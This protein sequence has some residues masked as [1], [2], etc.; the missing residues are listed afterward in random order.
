M[1]AVWRAANYC[2][3]IDVSPEDATHVALRFPCMESYLILPVIQRGSRDNH[4]RSPVWTWNGSTEAPTLK[5]SIRTRHE[6]GLSHV[7]L[8][9][10]RV[11]Y[12]NDSTHELAGQ[13]VDL[14]EVDW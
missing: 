6:K 3:Y 5:P 9:D 10:G 11:Q 7:W 14:Q 1:R 12:L 2:G 4:A 8:N 13:T